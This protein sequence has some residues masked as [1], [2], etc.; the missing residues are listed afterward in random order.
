[1]RA[2]ARC[3]V[4][5]REL[6]EFYHRRVPPY[7]PALASFDQGLNCL[8]GDGAMISLTTLP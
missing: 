2:Q 1:M 6:V 8:Y 7:N 5:A 3:R 4:S